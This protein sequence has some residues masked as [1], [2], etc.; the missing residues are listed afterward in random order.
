MS[1]PISTQFIGSLASLIGD[2]VDAAEEARDS[3]MSIE[4]ADQRELEGN[5]L[6]LLLYAPLPVFDLDGRY[7]LIEDLDLGLRYSGAAA[8]VDAKWHF[9]GN[10]SI[11]L[12][13]ILGYQYHFGYSKEFLKE[14]YGLFE[15]TAV[16]EHSRHDLDLGLLIS[17]AEDGGG[18]VVPYGGLRYLAAFN[19]VTTEF[20][21]SFLGV[22]ET[23]SARTTYSAT[24]HMVYG[25]GGL[26]IGS[27]KFQLQLE[28]TVGYAH[29]KPE[30]EGHQFDLSS[31]IITP[32]I[33]LSFETG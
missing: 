15:V 10:G 22:L 33:G 28:L 27:P 23:M 6:A 14:L 17:G 12:A 11:D 2:R 32:A 7:G 9:F 29:L 1:L 26:R 8:R 25:V 21:T 13:A 16:L 31:V 20:S 5:V 19:T 24:M 30:V 4:E 18:A 3:M